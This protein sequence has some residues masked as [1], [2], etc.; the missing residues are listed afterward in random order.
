MKQAADEFHLDNHRWKVSCH[1]ERD[2]KAERQIQCFSCA[3]KKKGQ[4]NLTGIPEELFQKKNFS[5]NQEV[6]SFGTFCREV[7]YFSLWQLFCVQF[8]KFQ[9]SSSPA[10]TQFWNR[11]HGRVLT[12][13]GNQRDC[14]RGLSRQSPNE[15]RFVAV[16][17]CKGFLSKHALEWSFAPLPQFLFTKRAEG[18]ANIHHGKFTITFTFITFPNAA[19]YHCS[20]IENST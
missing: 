5:C 2:W 10:W 20:H 6:F 13:F 19:L 14:I 12:S 18:T 4:Q 1:L 11:Q 16:F 17:Q 7:I 3:K 15:N 9:P 8:H